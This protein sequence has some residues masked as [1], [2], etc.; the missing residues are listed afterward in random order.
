VEVLVARVVLLRLED[1][2]ELLLSPFREEVTLDP[3]L[4]AVLA[5]LDMASACK[6]LVDLISFVVIVRDGG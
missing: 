6:N 5:R 4:D 1:L 3:S 2:S